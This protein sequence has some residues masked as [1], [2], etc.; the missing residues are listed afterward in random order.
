MPHYSSP[1]AQKSQEQTETS[2]LTA[3]IA[4]AANDAMSKNGL[5]NM[6]G[7][8]VDQDRDR[9][10]KIDN[11][12]ADKLNG[13]I[14]QLQKA[15]K[16]KYQQDFD[17]KPKDFA[18][19]Q[20]VSGQIQDPQQFAQN[21][22][23]SLV[24]SNGAQQA[25]AHSNMLDE[26]TRT[27]GNIEKGRNVAV[28]CLPAENG[29]PAMNVSLIHEAGGWKIDVPNDR[30][31]QQI[32]DDVLTQLTQIGED[33]AKLPSDAQQ[34]QAVVSRRILAAIYGT[35]LSQAD[36]NQSEQSQ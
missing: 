17:A 5:D 33:T 27:Q 15:W 22:P 24:S 1:L 11:I 10:S 13:R 9:L 6:V 3:P 7:N 19:A 8:F 29:L 32:H 30:T 34:A 31:A 18:S 2:S 23:L 21:W 16:D 26:E 28:V 35:N 25:A 14:E 12:N 4:A 20:S 36:Q